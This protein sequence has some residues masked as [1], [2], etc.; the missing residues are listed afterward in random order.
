MIARAR[1]ASLFAKVF[2]EVFGEVCR[3]LF[4]MV[5]P[6]SIGAVAAGKISGK[7]ENNAL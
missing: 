7:V 5:E 1:S 6:R 3:S 2:G 4:C